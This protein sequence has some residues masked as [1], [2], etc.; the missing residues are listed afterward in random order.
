MVSKDDRT[1]A[2]NSATFILNIVVTLAILVTLGT[3]KRYIQK[4]GLLD[5][6]SKYLEQ[7]KCSLSRSPVEL[8]LAVV[9]LLE[10]R[11]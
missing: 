1:I 2:D 11:H 7:S 10:P 3:R 4:T 5:N 9:S 8:S 6:M